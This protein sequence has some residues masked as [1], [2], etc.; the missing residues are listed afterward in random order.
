MASWPANSQTK[1][2]QPEKT[3]SAKAFAKPTPKTIAALQPRKP[4]KQAAF[5]STWVFAQS[6]MVVASPPPKKIVATPSNAKKPTSACCEKV[7][8][9]R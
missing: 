2:A 5:A 3:V 4:A 9:L 1:F 6:K 8:A 7:S